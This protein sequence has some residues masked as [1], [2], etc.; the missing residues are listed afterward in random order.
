MKDDAIEYVEQDKIKNL[1]KRYSEFINY[2]ISL[3]LSKEERVEVPEETPNE[4]VKVTREGEENAD[5]DV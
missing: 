1:V 4:S 5:E 3:Y 2:P